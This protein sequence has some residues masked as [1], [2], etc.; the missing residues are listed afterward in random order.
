[1]NNYFYIAIVLIAII[2][3]WRITAGFR[4]G[5]V[6]E[7]LSLVAMALAGVSAY[8]ILGAV[9]SY[10]SGEI[11]R[12]IQIVLFLL[13][14]GMLYKLIHLIFTSLKLVSKLPVVH[15]ADKL[16]GAVLGLLEGSVAVWCAIY[17]IKSWG[18][19]ILDSMPYL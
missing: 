6:R 2:L 10:L 5:F 7:L 9:G 13:V 19:S 17:W 4:K 14:I 15:G 16:L 1:M 11:G 18:L 8:L 3:I 12:L